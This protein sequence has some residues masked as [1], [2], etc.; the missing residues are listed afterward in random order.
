[1]QPERLPD[2]RIA[3]VPKVGGAAHGVI[4]E[5]VATIGPDDP[6]YAAWDVWL[7]RYE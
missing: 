5:G 2:G 3:N 4:A 1:M 6:D 7:R